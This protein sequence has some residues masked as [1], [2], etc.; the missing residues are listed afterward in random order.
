M[1]VK[2]VKGFTL[3]ELIIGITVCS[4]YSFFC[5]VIDDCKLCSNKHWSCK[6]DK[7]TTNTHCG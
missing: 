2:A 1:P 4:V 5:H 6:F 3:V 7:L